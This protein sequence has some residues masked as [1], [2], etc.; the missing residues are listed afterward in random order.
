MKKKLSG[1]IILSLGFISLSLA[2]SDDLTNKIS[3]TR[4]SICY[5]HPN[6]QLCLEGIN[7]LLKI[8]VATTD[9][10]NACK[11]VEKA[12]GKKRDECSQAESTVNWIRNN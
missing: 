6:K 11:S 8:A 12:G 5:N 2:A 1:I 7:A 4:E 3:G 9:A 10:V